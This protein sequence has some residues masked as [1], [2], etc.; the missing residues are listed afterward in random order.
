MT[1]LLDELFVKSDELSVEQIINE[2][3]NDK[4]LMLKTEIPNPDAILGLMDIEHWL[5]SSKCTRSADVI[6][7]HIE[8]FVLVMVSYDRKRVT[9]ILDGV[10]QIN[11]QRKLTLND[12]MF[13][14]PK[15][16]P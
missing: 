6:K 11:A 1:T 2:L 4:N 10:A 15:G 3:M 12:K 5:R 13:G 16:M 9:E 7:K 8:D 14:G